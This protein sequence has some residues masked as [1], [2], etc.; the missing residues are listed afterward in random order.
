MMALKNVLLARGI[1]EASA[2]E[3]ML[4]SAITRAVR[5]GG[6]GDRRQGGGEQGHRK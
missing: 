5:E 3:P 6:P 2:I 4:C 1:Q